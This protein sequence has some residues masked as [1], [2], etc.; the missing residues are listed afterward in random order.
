[1]RKEEKASTFPHSFTRCKYSFN[2]LLDEGVKAFLKIAHMNA[3]EL[4]YM[5]KDIW[6]I[7]SA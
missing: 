5:L 1:V 6:G 2:I 4:S 3:I 7:F